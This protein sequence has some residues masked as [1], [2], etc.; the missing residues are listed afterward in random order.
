MG[1][2]KSYLLIFDHDMLKPNYSTQA[3]PR[4]EHESFSLLDA[5]RKYGA[6]QCYLSCVVHGCVLA[7]G[8]CVLATT[9]LLKA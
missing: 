2:L 1:R 5:T 9:A 7:A 3:T 4:V 6:S 8:L